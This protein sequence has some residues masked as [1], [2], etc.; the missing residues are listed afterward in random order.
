[1]DACL[2]LLP[3]LT[4]ANS[5]NITSCHS[6]AS[7]GQPSPPQQQEQQQGQE[8]QRHQQQGQEQ[9]LLQTLLEELA[10]LAWACLGIWPE[11]FTRL[12]S[13]HSSLTPAE[14]EAALA[15]E[16]EPLWQLHTTACRLLHWAAAQGE[17]Q[18]VALQGELDWEAMTNLYASTMSQVWAIHHAA[19]PPNDSPEAGTTAARCV[20]SL[21]S[22]RL[23]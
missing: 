10:R 23:A 22:P 12:H 7:I 4:Q 1:M 3:A 13:F 14:Q 6:N 17:E 9:S 18:L 20:A 2:R 19:D 8:Q 21:A 11:F 5:L 15:E 16:A